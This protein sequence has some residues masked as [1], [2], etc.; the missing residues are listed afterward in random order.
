M[1]S[2]ANT[3]AVRFFF[4]WMTQKWFFSSVVRPVGERKH[5]ARR[6]WLIYA[7]T[8]LSH[9]E[10]FLFLRNLQLNRPGARRAACTHAHK[11][12]HRRTGARAHTH[13]RF[14]AAWRHHLFAEV[15]SVVAVAWGKG[16]GRGGG[17]RRRKGRKRRGK[18][19]LRII[20]HEVQLS[21]ESSVGANRRPLDSVDAAELKFVAATA[22]QPG[23]ATR[24]E[25]C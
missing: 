17:R 13:T 22:R 7:S 25:G 23:G 24:G 4:S 16:G 14:A 19:K 10:D 20:S 3:T 8:L 15:A 12:A 2:T 11:R 9:D 6:P 1:K 21:R 5:R 18:K